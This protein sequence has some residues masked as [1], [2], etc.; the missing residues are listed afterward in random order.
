MTAQDDAA[1]ELIELLQGQGRIRESGRGVSFLDDRGIWQEIKES[2][3]G[4]SE[5][6]VRNRRVRGKEK[7]LFRTMMMIRVFRHIGFEEFIKTIPGPV[8]FPAVHYSIYV[9]NNQ[10]PF[11]EDIEELIQTVSTITPSEEEGNY[12]IFSRGEY[13]DE[14]SPFARSPFSLRSKSGKR[15][16][17]LFVTHPPGF[18]P[19]LPDNI[20]YE[21][22]PF[23][24]SSVEP[25]WQ[26]INTGSLFPAISTGVLTVSY[27]PLTKLE[28]YIY[29]Q[30]GNLIKLDEN[31]PDGGRVLLSSSDRG[32]FVDILGVEPTRHFNIKNSGAY[33]EQ[34]KSYSWRRKPY[35]NPVI[36]FYRYTTS[37]NFPEY[38]TY[39]ELN[40][41]MAFINT[42]ARPNLPYFTIDYS[43][44]INSVLNGEFG[45]SFR[46]LKTGVIFYPPFD[47]KKLDLKIVPYPD[48]TG[49][50]I[51]F[52]DIYSVSYYK[53]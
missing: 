33:I 17:F 27:R 16:G 23:L 29:L 4:I 53:T 36:E 30:N 22:K 39:N 32:N 15:V 8:I 12:F 52:Y 3:A 5:N 35:S 45:S 50:S 1:K 20:S 21:F 46:Q 31:L 7:S 2:S 49:Y 38:A 6:V 9:D 14:D 28:Y 48:S 42:N 24:F 18:E 44:E 25:N 37:S 47:L 43:Y 34:A 19:I 10:A 51:E 26:K 40:N 11:S 41:R 13:A